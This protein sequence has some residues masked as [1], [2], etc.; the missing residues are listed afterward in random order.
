MVLADSVSVASDHVAFFRTQRAD[1]Y[2]DTI[3]ITDLT[4]RG[5]FNRTTKAYDT[6][7]TST[8][9][10]GGAL[11]RP[12]TASTKSRGGEGEVIFDVDIQLPYTAT[13]IQVGNQVTVDASV[14]NADL[15][16]EVL[17]VAHVGQV[18]TYDTH[19]LLGCNLSQGG[20]DRG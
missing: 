7:S 11:L 4:S 5:T 12:G 19:R 16:G 2:V 3:T 18:D 15:V 20:G 17:T 1:R 6:P 8:V 10:N 9:Y 14:L 13:G